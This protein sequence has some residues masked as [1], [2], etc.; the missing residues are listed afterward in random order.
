ATPKM[1]SRRLIASPEAQDQRIVAA[2]TSQ[3]MDVR[4]DRLDGK[5]SGHIFKCPPVESS[6]R[7]IR[8]VDH[9]NVR[10]IWRN[11]FERLQPL[12]IIESSAWENPVTLPLRARLFTQPLSTGSVPDRN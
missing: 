12:P 8:I 7:V 4:D 1:N 9:R 2:Q 10:N 11:F 6:S 3:T 5:R